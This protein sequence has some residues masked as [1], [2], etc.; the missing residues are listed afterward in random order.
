MCYLDVRSPDLQNMWLS[1][2]EKWTALMKLQ[3]S[4]ER[5]GNISERCY[6]KFPFDFKLSCFQK[7]PWILQFFFSLKDSCRVTCSQF[8]FFPLKGGRIKSTLLEFEPVAQGSLS[9]STLRHQL[10][11]YHPPAY[12]K[13]HC[14]K[15]GNRIVMMEVLGES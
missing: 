15:K 14:I 10:L 5:G 4:C 13:R 7:A 3:H 11:S 8:N 9:N 2:I 12:D 6:C 1:L